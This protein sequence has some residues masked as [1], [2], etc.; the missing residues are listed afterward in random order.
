MI[1]I[2]NDYT[3][4]GEALLRKVL[5]SRDFELERVQSVYS[6]EL[7]KNKIL[8]REN[9]LLKEEND[10]LWKLV[11]LEEKIKGRFK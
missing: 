11:N 2:S 10:R 7:R 6:E 5:L 9:L 8:E 4:Y 3:N 1:N